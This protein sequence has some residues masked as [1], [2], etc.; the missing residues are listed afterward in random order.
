MTMKLLFTIDKVLIIKFLKFG[1]VGFSGLIVDFG[2]TS[3]FKEVFHCNKY[4]SN[5]IGFVSAATSNYVLNRLWTF[6]SHNEA[7]G[8]EY[9][10]FMIVSVIGLVI[11]TT[12]LYIATDKFKLN[13]YFS[14]IIAIGVATLWN[15]FGNMLITFA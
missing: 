10:Q 3:L 7:I 11:N 14:K 4:L 8:A 9:L 1:A 13:F 5:T 2:L 15:F 12:V 6:Q